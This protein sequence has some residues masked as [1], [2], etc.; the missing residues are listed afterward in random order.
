MAEVEVEGLV[1]L[2]VG[3]EEDLVVPQ[4]SLVLMIGIVQCMSYW[5]MLL[6]FKYSSVGWRILICRFF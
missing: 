1:T 3:V 4:D 6:L 5:A 2:G